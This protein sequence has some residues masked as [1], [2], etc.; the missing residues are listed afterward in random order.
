MSLASVRP[1]Q[2]FAMVGRRRPARGQRAFSDK[3]TGARSAMAVWESSKPIPDRPGYR[4]DAEGRVWW[5]EAFL[6]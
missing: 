6:R 2:A 5:S 3:W 4:L 1:E